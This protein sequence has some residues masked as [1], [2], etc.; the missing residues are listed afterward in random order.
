MIVYI[1]I[2]IIITRSLSRLLINFFYLRLILIISARCY[3][4]VEFWGTTFDSIYRCVLTVSTFDVCVS[5]CRGAVELCALNIPLHQLEQK[6]LLK[7][8]SL[9]SLNQLEFA[10][11]SSQNKNI[12]SCSV[13]VVFRAYVK[14]RKF[15]VRYVINNKLS[16][17]PIYISTSV[18]RESSTNWHRFVRCC[19]LQFH[20]WSGCLQHYIRLHFDVW[21]WIERKLISWFFFNTFSLC[22]C[23]LFY[24]FYFPH[25]AWINSPP[26]LIYRIRFVAKILFISFNVAS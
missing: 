15:R 23:S 9:L 14:V 13:F 5:L 10:V 16:Q 3:F 12:Y 7:R 18:S 26:W 21:P 2:I 11:R 4:F 20:V 22:S 25:E 19:R 1:I 17:Q 6:K 8:L 24:L